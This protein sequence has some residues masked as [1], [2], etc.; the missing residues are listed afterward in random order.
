M[1]KR[2]NSQYAKVREKLSYFSRRPAR[3]DVDAVKI[4][5]IGRN[6]TGT[7]SLASFFRGNGYKVGNQEQAELLL[8]DWTRR[9][10]SRII[11]YCKTAE[12][13]Q[14]IPF[15]LPDTYKALDRAFPGSKFILSVRSSPEEWYNSLVAHHTKR[16]SSTAG[17]PPS[18]QD[19]GQFKYRRKY[20]G[21]LLFAQ[22]AIYGYPSVPLY[23][24]QAYMAHYEMHNAEVRDYFKSR[25]RDLLVLNLAD[26]DAFQELCQFVGLELANVVPLPHLN[27]SREMG[28][29][30]RR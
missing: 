1:M 21:W 27:R 18:E 20:K 9:D 10:F 29:R 8:E 25:P 14:D 5:C 26:E 13:F 15:S 23:D 11:E 28:G 22:Q 2:L 30:S 16:F 6:K 17:L 12:V 24:K 3:Q 19:L 7:T 4:F